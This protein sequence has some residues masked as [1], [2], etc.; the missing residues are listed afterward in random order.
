LANGLSSRP[1][2]QISERVACQ[3]TS[4]ILVTR[5]DRSGFLPQLS[6]KK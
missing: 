6:C 3:A 5:P 1:A 4:I 2:T